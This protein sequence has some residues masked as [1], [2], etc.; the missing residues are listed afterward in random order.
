MPGPVGVIATSAGSALVNGIINRALAPD[1]E[2]GVNLT[3]PQQNSQ[4][5]GLNQQQVGMQQSPDPAA[6]LLQAQGPELQQQLAQILQM[7]QR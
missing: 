5:R 6:Q 4:L 3:D 1:P 2:T 7:F